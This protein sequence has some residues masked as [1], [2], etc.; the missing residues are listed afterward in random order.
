VLALAFADAPDG[1]DAHQARKPA[2][3][4]MPTSERN[5]PR[6]GART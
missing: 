4:S 2:G 3:R 6:P 5:R 1:P